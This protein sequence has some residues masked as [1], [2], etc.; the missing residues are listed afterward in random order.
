MIQWPIFQR[1]YSFFIV[2]THLVKGRQS[3]TFRVAI[4]VRQLRDLRSR[5]LH[6]RTQLQLDGQQLHHRVDGSEDAQ[7]GGRVL[8]RMRGPRKFDMVHACV[9]I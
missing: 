3:G 4:D 7:R 6:F 1:F 5:H 2:E 8:Q 9:Y